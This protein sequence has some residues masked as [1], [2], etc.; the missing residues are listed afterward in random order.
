MSTKPPVDLSA[1]KGDLPVP[2][3]AR[4]PQKDAQPLVR[5][6]KRLVDAAT[7]RIAAA[8]LALPVAVGTIGAVLPTLTGCGPSSKSEV[9][10]SGESA[11][12][13][14]VRVRSFSDS[15]PVNC[16]AA[17]SGLVWVG[18]ARGLVRWT[19]TTD[20]PT[21]AVLTTI[22]GL[23]ADRI[24]AISLDQKGGVWVTTPKGVSRF[25]SGS[26]T[27]YPK[28]PV[29]D[30]VAG[31]VASSDGEHAWVGGSD[32][33]ARLRD[34]QWDRFA[35]GTTVTS[36][37]SDGG[38]GAWIGTSGK[39]IMRVVRD[40]LL[41]YGMAE[42]N[43]ID[44]VRAMVADNNNTVL[45][46]GDGPGGQ[47][48]AYFDGSRF[49]SY[50][51]EAPGVMEW[52][53]R[54]GSDLYLGAGQQVWSMKRVLPGAKL[55]GPVKF[56]FSGSAAIGAPK[57]QPLASMKAQDAPPPPPPAPDAAKP[58][59]PAKTDPA[60]APGKGKGKKGKKSSQ[61]EVPADPAA[62]QYAQT[63]TYTASQ[64][65]DRP[66]LIAG[67]GGHS[68]GPPV[69]DTESVDVRLPDGITAVS[70]DSDSLYIGTRFLGVT[71]IQK[72]K[73]MPLRLF[74]LTAGAERLSVAC[75]GQSDCYVATG[76]TQAWRFDGQTFEVTDVDPEKGSHVLAVVRDPQAAVI[77]LH[78][79]AAS[80]EVRI[81]R[82]GNAGKWF[83]VG[84]TSLEVP[85]GVPDLSF[86]T[87]SPKGQLWVGLRY[88]DKDQDARAFGAA[89]VSVD[90]GRV[91]YHRQRPAGVT[92]NVSQG[93]NVP[94]DVN[95]IAFKGPDEAWLASRSGAVRLKDNK[96]V[97]VFTENDGLESELVHDVVE[98]LNGQMWIATSRG[99]GVWNGERWAFPK[100]IPFNVKASALVR[101]PDGRIWIGTDRGVLE[102]ADGKKTVTIGSRTGL[103]DDKVLNMGVDVR[104]RIWVL[105]E[106]GISVI[107]TLQ[108]N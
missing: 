68:G 28:P 103:L 98:G 9:K 27:N 45:A 1:E 77:A 40:D 108:A 74:D 16:L 14:P 5:R 58:A 101:D 33:I 65:P 15:R 18:T 50:R 75:I 73:V 90:D 51:I 10:A 49:W 29:G 43:D 25:F 8:A 11:I 39:G 41:Q 63:V 84:V 62:P 87:F 81:S 59:D 79:G 100:E 104:G 88:V 97:K 72:G 93:V 99:I 4:R 32:G 89:E 17:A 31:I 53:Q 46:V 83:P 60:A 82:V 70:A 94:S 61:L 22:D 69:F 38:N 2:A 71:R 64:H 47:R 13:A 86:A 56:S 80:K 95:A 12:T 91:I 57:A 102:V 37:V 52:V 106:K 35:A 34:G 7:A 21:P 92:R 67:P 23:P 30:L 66:W 20:P 54:V 85:T 55:S 24:T 105:T 36:I 48:A 3:I 96:T 26:W 19:T 107:E 42:G 78:R 6:R 76:G 44:N